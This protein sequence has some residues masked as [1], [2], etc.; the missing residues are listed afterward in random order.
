MKR[1]VLIVV[2]FL[3]FGCKSDPNNVSFDAITSNLTPELQTLTERPSD[4]HRNIAVSNNQDW[5]MF[6][7]D[8][9]RVWMTDGPSSM[10]PYPIVN[11]S[12]NPE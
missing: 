6:S 7:E 10:S 5:R 3:L 11:L 8:L 9:G 2:P 12:G 1:T 4:V